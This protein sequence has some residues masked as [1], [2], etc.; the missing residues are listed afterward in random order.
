M[1]LDKPIRLLRDGEIAYVNRDAI[2]TDTD[3]RPYV[4]RE[5][6]CHDKRSD[7]CVMV[8]R[9]G[10]VLYADQ[11]DMD[12]T[13]PEHVALEELRTAQYI[14]ILERKPFLSRGFDP[15]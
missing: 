6:T 14:L 9:S 2:V 4:N 12:A 11:Q 5:T 10:T 8:Q 13:K 7:A 1:Q 3:E 15:D